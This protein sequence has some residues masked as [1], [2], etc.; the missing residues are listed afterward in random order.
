MGLLRKLSLSLFGLFYQWVHRGLQG[1]VLVFENLFT[2]LVERFKLSKAHQQSFSLA[3]HWLK[4]TWKLLFLLLP[5]TLF[6]FHLAFNLT[7]LKFLLWL[8]L[9]FNQVPKFFIISKHFFPNLILLLKDCFYLCVD[10]DSLFEDRFFELCSCLYRC[11]YIVFQ[12]AK[13]A[14]YCL[15]CLFTTFLLNPPL[16]IKQVHE[17]LSPMQC[18][19]P[20]R[21]M[22]SG[23]HIV[24]SELVD[25]ATQY[26]VGRGLFLPSFLPSAR[27]SLQ[28]LNSDLVSFIDSLQP[29]FKFNALLTPLFSFLILLTLPLILSDL[30]VT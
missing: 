22:W 19:L 17:L 23:L 18:L 26:C 15:Y 13:W 7:Q 8:F 4:P 30:F 1:S 2:R 16:L 9:L 11:D 3:L 25:L 27:F 6:L 28:L 5:F 24:A 20:E 12:G 21:G 10:F 29:F 14:F